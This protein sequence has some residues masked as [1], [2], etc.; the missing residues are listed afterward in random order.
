MTARV[1]ISM[2]SRIL[3]R[4]QSDI[5]RCLEAEGWA[6]GSHPTAEGQRLGVVIIE[7]EMLV[8]GNGRRKPLRVMRLTGKG[9]DLL[10][11]CIERMA[12][13]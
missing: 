12:A 1:S 6:I 11:R 2:A 5:R 13:A 10:S 9:L 3:G 8:L 7:D 4:S